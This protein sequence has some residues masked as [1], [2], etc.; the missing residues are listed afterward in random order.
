MRTYMA[1]PVAP[2]K[3]LVV[4][5]FDG[6]VNK[7]DMG[8]EPPLGSVIVD[9]T[10]DRGRG[11]PSGMHLND[12]A[13]TNPSFLK[14][15]LEILH[16]NNVHVVL[17]SQRIL[18]DEAEADAQDNPLA[19]YKGNLAKTMYLGLDAVFGE[20]RAYLDKASA[21]E[22]REQ[23]LAGDHVNT[24]VSKADLIA[25]Y[26]RKFQVRPEDILLID[27]DETYKKD[28]VE[29]GHVFVHAP[30]RAKPGSM[31]DNAYLYETLLRTVP[32]KQIYQSIKDS[33]ASLDEKA[34]FIK[35]LLDFRFANCVKVV[36]WQSDLSQPSSDNA[37]LYETL[38]RTTPVKQIYQSIKNSSA[39][40]AEKEVFEK[41]L[42]DF[43][44]ARLGEVVSWQGALSPPP[45]DL[46]IDS[47][48][49]ASVATAVSDGEV[50]KSADER[51]LLGI[52]SLILGNEWKVGR[53]GG[54]E[55]IDPETKK[56]IK[57]PT[58]M[59]AILD[60]IGQAEKDG[61]WGAALNTV[62]KTI[63]I[64]ESKQGLFSKLGTR[65]SKTQDFYTHAKDML[66][67]MRYGK[68]TVEDPDENYTE[69]SSV[70]R[71]TK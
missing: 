30:R 65:D 6:P 8:S 12:F 51:V 68:V 36:S 48:D 63:S 25:L 70:S 34:I 56:S 27:D 15:S 20:G 41:Q 19:Q 66:E 64:F 24:N 38:L 58:G 60:A 1:T 62:E 33:N 71:H 40:K 37:D 10:G 29:A 39:S 32:L 53:F 54:K 46:A 61:R 59:K 57:L 35:Q 44:F 67:E 31:E 42:L 43:Q 16:Q 5:D 28:T 55:Y 21:K 18:M 52:K 13:A 49:T 7:V 45:K 2:R 4:L 11:L 22:I 17:G 14:L 3:K 50:E 9:Y 47:E 23:Y 69:A 26:Q